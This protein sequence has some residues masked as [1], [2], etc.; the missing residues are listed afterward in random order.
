MATKKEKPS[1]TAKTPKGSK[2]DKVTVG[3]KDPT[4]FQIKMV[5]TL[6][7]MLKSMAKTTDVKKISLALARESLS[8][9]LPRVN[10]LPEEVTLR[11]VQRRTK[12]SI[13]LTAMAVTLILALTWLIQGVTINSANKTYLDAQKQVAVSQS[14]D[15]KLSPIQNYLDTLKTRIDLTNAKIGTKL[16]YT[17]LLNNIQSAV[18]GSAQISTLSTRLITP[19]TDKPKPGQVVSQASQCGTNNDP[20]SPDK[21]PIIACITFTGTANSRGQMDSVVNQLS[22]IPF[23]SNISVDQAS[24]ITIGSTSFTFTGTAAVNNK[25]LLPGSVVTK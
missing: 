25:I 2:K 19:S 10:L 11:V 15:N 9:T 7:F 17:K 3:L 22:A 14:Q 24:Q 16:D 12:F 20:F 8:N 4:S 21:F 1:K 13:A 23:L 18:G 5:K 6:P